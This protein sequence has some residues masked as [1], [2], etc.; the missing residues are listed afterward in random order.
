MLRR[1]HRTRQL[2]RLDPGGQHVWSS[3]TGWASLESLG[4][5]A[6][7]NQSYA[8]A[9]ELDE[10]DVS[11]SLVRKY[12]LT[13]TVA[14]G[15][16]QSFGRNDLRQDSYVWDH[17]WRFD[18]ARQT[19]WGAAMNFDGPSSAVVREYFIQNALYW[20][21]DPE[22]Y[23]RAGG[24]MKQLLTLR[25]NG[26]DQELAVPHHW[27]LLE[28][29]QQPYLL[30]LIVRRQ[31]AAMYAASLLGLLN[32]PATKIAGV[33]QA[34]AAQLARVFNAYATKDAA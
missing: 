14:N 15:H 16:G 11:L 26:M 6:G 18:A 34:P 7:G 25:I 13:Q 10:G 5:D 9:F 17:A 4:A 2:L 32:A 1:V 3:N 33:V 20:V 23:V 8:F 22:K 12:G 19:P 21:V 30:R 28:V 29:L 24:S 27:S 31:L